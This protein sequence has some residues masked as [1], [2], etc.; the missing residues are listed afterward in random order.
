MV[1]RVISLAL[2]LHL[3]LC[4]VRRTPPELPSQIILGYP[5]NNE[6]DD[7]VLSA[8]QD[9]VNLVMW[10]AVVIAYNETS[11]LPVIESGPDYACVGEMASQIREMGLLTIHM[12]S[13]GGWGAPHPETINT[14]EEVYQALDDWNRNIVANPDIGFNGFDG[15][16]W[17]VE[18]TNDLAS[19]NNIFS[20]ACLELMGKV[21]Q[22]AKQDGYLVSMVPG[23][24]CMD[25]T[26]SAFDRY[27]N[28]TY[29]QWVSVGVDFA[30]HGHNPYAY[31]LAKY[32]QTQTATGPVDTFDFITIQLYE[33]YSLADYYL[34]EAKES[35]SSY[36][37][38]FVTTLTEGWVVDFGSDSVLS[39]PSQVVKVPNSKLLIGLANGWATSVTGVVLILPSDLAPVHQALAAAG[40][41]PRGYAYW[42]I[43]DEGEAPYANGEPLN[44]AA[45]INEFL[46]IRNTT[47]CTVS[48]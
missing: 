43:A 15:F 33:T 10:F 41:A 31:L 3:S 9:G 19:P 27:L 1:L 36:L 13:I 46:C 39:F 38:T 44:M 48:A 2:L 35:L 37:T 11:G 7:K 20:P 8:V 32:G 25:P 5:T 22:L 29:A 40:M 4:S 26:T 14:P 24:S 12:V 34:N 18:G 6:C 45:G 16:D 17:D 23:A 30:Y 28:H 21:S 47:K 42:T